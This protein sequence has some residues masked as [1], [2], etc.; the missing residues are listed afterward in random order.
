MLDINAD[1]VRVRLSYGKN[2]ISKSADSVSDLP[3]ADGFLQELRE[4]DEPITAYSM[5][6][7]RN[8]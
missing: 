2:E 4:I 5:R 7:V 3:D 6:Q 8:F 1:S